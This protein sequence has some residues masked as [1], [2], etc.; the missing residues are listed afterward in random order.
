M[1]LEYLVGPKG[2]QQTEMPGK[3]SMVSDYASYRDLTAGPV[4]QTGSPLDIAIQGPGYLTVQGP[5]GNRYS[6]GGAMSLNNEGTLVDRNGLP[7]LDDGGG[8]IQ[9]PDGTTKIT[10]SGDGTVSVAVEGQSNAQNQ[11]GKIGLVKF[12][13]P[14][15]ME[16]QAGGLYTSPDPALP[17]LDTRVQQGALEQSNV[18]PVLE[19]TDMITIQRSYQSVSKMLDTEHERERNAISKLSRIA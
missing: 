3:M 18:N 13:R 12:D 17:D 16:Q 2:G 9:I 11:I 6:R 5:N 14:Q 10:I 19:M 7:V 1:F 8:Q 15:F 4:T